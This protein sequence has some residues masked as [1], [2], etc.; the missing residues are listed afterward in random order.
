MAATREKAVLEARILHAAFVITV[1]LFIFCTRLATPPPRPVSRELLLAIAGLTVA[2]IMLGF[3]M[4]QKFMAKAG[5]PFECK[6]ENSGLEAWRSANICSFAHAEAVTLFGVTLK[7]LGASW[8]IAGPFF[9]IGLSLLLLWTPRLDLPLTSD[10]PT[11]PPPP[12]K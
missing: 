11:A 1:I 7:F 8:K 3:T 5:E 2:D 12:V 9:F 4:R 6:G 10:A